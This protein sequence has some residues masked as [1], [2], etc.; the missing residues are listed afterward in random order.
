MFYTFD[1]PFGIISIAPQIFL[2]IGGVIIFLL[3]FFLFKSFLKRRAAL[4]YSLDKAFLLVTLPPEMTE[5]EKKK[6]MEELL[7]PTE[8]FFD[9]VAGLRA[10]RGVKTGLFGRSDHFSFEIFLDKDG[11]IS[12]YVVAPRYLQQFFEEQIH[13]QYPNASIEE[14]DEYNA[15][16]EQ[17][18][19]AAAYFRLSQP[20]ILPIKTY[21]KLKTDPL[22]S[23]VNAVSKI[24]KGNQAV[25]QVITRSA[26]GE[27]H[28]RGAKIAQEMKQGKKFTEA[29]GPEKGLFSKILKEIEQATTTQPKKT[30]YEEEKK[31]YQLSPMEDEVVKNLEEKTSK[32][33][34][35]VNIRV[36]VSAKDKE[37]AKMYLDNILNSYAQYSIYHYGNGLLPTK[38]RDKRFIED[39]IYRNLDEAQS[40]ILNSE[41]MTSIFH[42]PLPTLNIP[43]IKWV[44]AK[45]APV[46]LGVPDEGLILGHNLYRGVDKIVRIKKLDRM[47]HIYI[48]GQTG[49][50]KSTLLLNMAVQDAMNKEGFCLIDPHGDLIETVLGNIPEERYDDLI[51]FEPG[52][53]ERPMGLNLLDYDA[54]YPE[55]KTFVINEMIEIMDKLYDLKQTGGPMFEQY[56]RNAML[57]VMAHPESGSTLMEVPRVL[58]DPDFR[59]YKLDHCSNQVVNDF[60]IKEAEKAGGE[61][62]LSNMTPYITS[63]LNQFTANDIMR[64][65]IGQQKSAIN[66][67]EAMDKGK[68]ILI[69]LAKG[70]I[71]DLN[72]YLLGLI[73]VGKILISALSRVD[74][75]ETERKDFYLYV[76]EFQNFVTE[77][78][79]TILSES[80]KYHL[81]LGIAHQYVGQLVRGQD[82]QIRD[83]VFGNIGTIISYKIGVEDAQTLEKQFTPVFNVHDLINVPKFSAYIS[84]IADNQP[85]RPFSIMTYPPLAGNEE[86]VRLLRELSHRKYGR[87]REIVEKEIAERFKI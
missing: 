16:L 83:A 11:S 38:T 66:F 70:K 34:L 12:F 51:L 65:I 54:S 13:A 9:N 62:A 56:M 33:G 22:E 79:A 1:T 25:I 57:L 31:R 23:I 63:K 86:K 39:F 3:S 60:W 19:V 71:G 5:E 64:P 87:P 46:P 30:P 77:S 8:N 45:T 10:Q 81:G 36:L 68:I 32:A 67:R 24:E 58:S 41:E 80:R 18:E 59:H 74:L 53:I 2:A 72:A 47:R 69:N 82:A 42:F 40:F 50:G 44:V 52:Y 21:K 73:I 4:R 27:W 20:W 43:S 28:K 6:T 35:D 55:Q 17:G 84:M 7:A 48:I 61:A 76:D 49:T 15:F 78:I 14:V 85:L 29:L 75:K 37:R 26:K